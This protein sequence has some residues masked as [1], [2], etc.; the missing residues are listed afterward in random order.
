GPRRVARRP[1]GRVERAGAGFLHPGT[2]H[3]RPGRAHPRLHRGRDRRDDQPPGRVRR[4]HHRG[5]RTEHGGK[6]E[7]AQRVARQPGGGGVLAVAPRA[8][9]AATGPVREPRVSALTIEY[10]EDAEDVAP[11]ERRREATASFRPGVG[12]WV[13]RGVVGAL[14]AAVVLLYPLSVQGFRAGEFTT[15]VIFAII[16]LSLKVII[17]YTGQNSHGHQAFVGV[18]AFTSAYV[19]TVQGQNFAIGVLAAAAVGGLQALIL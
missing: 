3:P 8:D 16:G 14:V 10:P 5:D 12:G 1:G 19:V 4:R 9:G 13:A 2:A 15:G 17:V 6:R 7:L 18:G 11:S